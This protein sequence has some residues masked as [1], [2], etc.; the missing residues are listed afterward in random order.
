MKY[1]M[2]HQW[3]PR[4]LR[5]WIWVLIIS[6]LSGGPVGL[7]AGVIMGIFAVPLN[8]AWIL[9]D[10]LYEW[11]ADEGTYLGARPSDKLRMSEKFRS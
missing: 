6:L 10:E 3:A 4:P 9:I 7:I 11:S 1:F 8:C 5:L 2:L